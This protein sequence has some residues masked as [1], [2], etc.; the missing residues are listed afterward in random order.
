L[1]QLGA[2]RPDVPNPPG[3]NYYFDIDFFVRG[4]VPIT[5]DDIAFQV[6]LGVPVGLTLNFLSGD[7]QAQ[8]DTFAFGYNYGFL[9]GG[10]VHFSKKFGMFVEVGW[11]T[12]RVS[13]DRVEASGSTDFEVSQSVANFGFIFGS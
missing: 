6:W 8:L 11:M 7:Y 9:L 3:R 12:H 13:H 2:W 4:R 10:A 1:F 5:T